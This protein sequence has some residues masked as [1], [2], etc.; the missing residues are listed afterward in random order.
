MD[1]GTML[2]IAKLGGFAILLRAWWVAKK[3]AEA[4]RAERAAREAA[5][6]QAK[7]SEAQATPP[8]FREAA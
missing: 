4:S 5:L 3:S 8:A 6:S 7:P 2:A 1:A